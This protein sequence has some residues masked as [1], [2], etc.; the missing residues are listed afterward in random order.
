MRGGEYA[1]QA[2]VEAFVSAGDWVRREGGERCGDEVGGKVRM[3]SNYIIGQEQ[4]RRHGR[5]E[6]STQLETILC[7][8]LELLSLLLFT[9]DIINYI[10]SIY[11]IC[12]AKAIESCST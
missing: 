2:P 11:N 12:L 1:D 8:A 6:G 7:L 3:R 5:K 10:V 4:R 9:A